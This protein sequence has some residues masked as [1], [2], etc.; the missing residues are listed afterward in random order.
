M[1]CASTS[2]GIVERSEGLVL[3]DGVGHCVTGDSYVRWVV[4]DPFVDAHFGSNP[5]RRN[6]M[7]RQCCIGFI[8]QWVSIYLSVILAKLF[9][10]LCRY[11]QT[12][13]LI[14]WL[15]CPYIATVARGCV[16]LYL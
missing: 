10:T 13:K 12:H 14:G 11:G 2:S 15:S 7:G 8:F 9:V 6:P 1:E 16:S 4:R 3:H 5:N